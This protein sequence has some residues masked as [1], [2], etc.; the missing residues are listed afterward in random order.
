V[1]LLLLLLLLLVLVLLPREDAAATTGGREAMD[2]E[3][4]EAP[5]PTL[6]AAR[7]HI[8]SNSK[9]FDTSVVAVSVDA[10]CCVRLVYQNKQVQT[11]D[12][13]T[14]VLRAACGMAVRALHA[15]LCLAQ[16]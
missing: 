10:F 14:P 12:A 5:E 6:K 11:I 7:R 9:A 8:C 4:Y 2:M 15:R 16:S 1:F 3:R 13:F